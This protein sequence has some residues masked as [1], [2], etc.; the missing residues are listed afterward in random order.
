MS[1]NVSETVQLAESKV[2][3]QSSDWPN[4]KVSVKTSVNG[5]RIGASQN[6]S[7]AKSELAGH[8]VRIV[9]SGRI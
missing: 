8:G 9:T 1:V 2:V 5:G 7:V 4:L 6:R 3:S